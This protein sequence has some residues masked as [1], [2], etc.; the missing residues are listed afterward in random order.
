MVKEELILKL[1]KELDKQKPRYQKLY[2]Y[3]E[4][5]HKILHEKSKVDKTRAD[6]R[7]V[8]NYC[9]KTV[10]NY[11]GYLLGKPINYSSRSNNHEFLDFIDTY[12]SGWEKAHNISLKQQTEIYGHAYEVSFINRDG[13]FQ[14]TYFNPLEMIAMHDGSIDRN[15]SVAVRKYNVEFNDTDYLDVWDDNDYC[16]YSL[17]GDTLNLIEQKPHFFSHCPVIEIIN[18]DSKKSA[19]EEII[20]VIDVYNKINSTAANE[21]ED[22]RSAYLVIENADLTQEQAEKMKQNG[23]IL[24]PSGA[25]VYWATKDINGAFVKDML[26]DWRDEIYIQTNQVNLNED[27]SSNT[28]GVAIRL[29]LQELENLVSIKESIFE[30]ALKKRIKLFC[31]WLDKAKNKQFTWQD[32]AITFAR[33][34]PVDE[35]SIVQMV[36]ELQGILPNEELISWLP[37]VSNPSALLEKLKQEN[38][39][40]GFDD[41]GEGLLDNDE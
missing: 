3:Y 14:C 16:K 29:K 41:T 19:F 31:E 4:G 6:E 39:S 2:N 23:I 36:K 40:Y 30:K 17:D 1:I 21:I 13:Q 11:T 35:S 10:S 24:A 9:K 12:F 22:H 25:K 15:V 27:F 28:S 33:N 5:K 34:V 7:V 37:R 18:N 38:D 32:I 26:K 8:Y 20:P